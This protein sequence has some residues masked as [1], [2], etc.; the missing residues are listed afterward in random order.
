M[1]KTDLGIKLEVIAHNSQGY[2]GDPHG[3]EELLYSTKTANSFIL[4]GKGGVDSKYANNEI[5]E[6]TRKQA[7]DYLTDVIG[8]EEALKVIP[9]PE[10]KAPAK[11]AA[12]KAKAGKSA[13]KAAPKAKAEKPASKAAPKKAEPAKKT[14]AQKPLAKKTETSKK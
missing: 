2:F 10:R 14:S 6:L 13:S 4:V 7:Q 1:D 11:K 5:L 8:K 12:P 3:Y 9:Q